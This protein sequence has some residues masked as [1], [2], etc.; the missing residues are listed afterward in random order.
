M[1]VIRM[2]Y[3]STCIEK[4]EKEKKPSTSVHWSVEGGVTFL[5]A[6]NLISDDNKEVLV[7]PG[8]IEDL[9]KKE[10]GKGSVTVASFGFPEVKIEPPLAP[11]DSGVDEDTEENKVDLT[12]ANFGVQ[13]TLTVLLKHRQAVVEEVIAKVWCQ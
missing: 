8:T 3:L 12:D 4:E 9:T 2:Q 11:K 7:D 10:E 5:G 6:N 13:V 1:K